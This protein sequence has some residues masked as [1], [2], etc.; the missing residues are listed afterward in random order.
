MRVCVAAS[1]QFRAT[2]CK[3]HR[4]FCVSTKSHCLKGDASSHL[5]RAGVSF[6]RVLPWFLNGYLFEKMKNAVCFY[7]SSSAVCKNPSVFKWF[8]LRLSAILVLSTYLPLNIVKPDIICGLQ[9]RFTKFTAHFL[10]CMQPQQDGPDKGE[11]HQMFIRISYFW[12]ITAP[13][14]KPLFWYSHI[15]DAYRVWH[16]GGISRNLIICGATGGTKSVGR[17][18][19]IM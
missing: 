2:C 7:I 1:T 3:K 8:M 6:S 11:A 17:A 5:R 12:E 13:A 18:S 10:D 14:C 16:P 4:V 9:N 15:A 19:F